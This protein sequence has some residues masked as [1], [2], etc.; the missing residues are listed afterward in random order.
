MGVDGEVKV[1][2]DIGRSIRVAGDK[3]G[4]VGLKRQEMAVAGDCDVEAGGVGLAAGRTEVGPDGGTG[5]PV[6]KEDIGVIVRVA[7]DKVA[8]FGVI[9]DESAVG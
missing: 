3:V 4:R 8:R 5:L 1:K 9:G 7:G 6:I 2:E